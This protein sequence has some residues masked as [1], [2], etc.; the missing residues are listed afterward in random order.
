MNKNSHIRKFDIDLLH[1]TLKL[2]FPQIKI[3]DDY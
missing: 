3:H 1:Y 2:L